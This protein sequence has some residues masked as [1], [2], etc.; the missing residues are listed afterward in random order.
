MN[1]EDTYSYILDI[2]YI[3]KLEIHFIRCITKNV[4]DNKYLID[5]NSIETLYSPNV[6]V[7]NKY[8]ENLKFKMKNNEI[9]LKKY[10]NDNKLAYLYDTNLC[11]E[12]I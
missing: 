11:E 8:V 4:G 12:R 10:N 9:I 1:L 2:T 6:W 3:N 5:V 7:K